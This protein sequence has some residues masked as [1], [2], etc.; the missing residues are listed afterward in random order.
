MFMDIIKWGYMRRGQRKAVF[1][2]YP[3]TTVIFR[4]V[5]GYFLVYSIGW[6]EKDGVIER[7]DISKMEVLLNKELGLHENYSERGGNA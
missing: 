2:K 7:D 1:D 3:N 5:R 6:D 4:R